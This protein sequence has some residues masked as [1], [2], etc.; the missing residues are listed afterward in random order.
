MALKE[1]KECNLSISS[2]A[3]KCPHCG[4]KVIRAQDALLSCGCLCLVAGM[5]LPLILIFAGGC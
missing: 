2:K 5:L 1:C 3:K 4:V